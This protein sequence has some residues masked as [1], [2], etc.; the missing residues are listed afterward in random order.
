MNFLKYHLYGS[1]YPRIFYDTGG[2]VAGADQILKSRLKE[3]DEEVKMISAPPPFHEPH[4]SRG[5]IPALY[6]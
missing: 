6:G 2:T 1:F 3:K 4:W 5:T